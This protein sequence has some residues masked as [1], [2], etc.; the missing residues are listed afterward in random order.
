MK[1]R[2]SLFV[3]VTKKFGEMRRG[4]FSSKRTFKERNSFQ[5][6]SKR[7]IGLKFNNLDKAVNS[8]MLSSVISTCQKA[9]S[10]MADFIKEKPSWP[11]IAVLG[12]INL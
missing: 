7:C 1:I 6:Q 9:R 11:P 3:M 2:T 10:V 4:C 12:D 8:A 5:D